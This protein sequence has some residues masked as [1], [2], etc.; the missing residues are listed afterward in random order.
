MASPAAIAVEGILSEDQ[1][2]Y[3][4]NKILSYMPQSETDLEKRL[5]KLIFLEDLRKAA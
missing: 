2:H 4:Q 5:K 1:S 3:A